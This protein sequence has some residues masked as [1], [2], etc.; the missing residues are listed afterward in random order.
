MRGGGI[1]KDSGPICDSPGAEGGEGRLRRRLLPT[2][3]CLVS[4]LLATPVAA[5]QL[6]PF[7]DR[8]FTYPQTL[9]TRD[10]GAYRVIDYRELRDINQRDAV[11]ERQV[12]GRYVSTDI[13]RLQQDLAADTKAGP[14]R[15]FAVGRPAH[16]R[17]ITIYLHGQGGNRHQGVNDFTFGG[18][19]NRIKNLMGR[20]GGLYLS[21]DVSD[22]GDKGAAKVAA[23]ISHYAARSPEAPVF[24]ACGSMGGA[25]CWRLARD[26]ALAPRLGGLLLLGSMWD[27]DFIES[28]AFRRRVP[29]LIAHGSRDTV[30]PIERQEAFYRAIGAA[31]PG[32]PVRFVRFETGTHGTPIRMT[33]WRETLNWM[34]SVRR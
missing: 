2:L 15:H 1:V 4:I 12:R 8:L 7:K 18:N 10:N 14:L 19:F 34:L 9:E 22:F 31:A 26:P 21:P 33:D 30:F 11:P 27:D 23:L 25:L 28:E 16:P 29:L 5:L 20:N 17:I 13:R 3:L 6:A 24:L 32:Y